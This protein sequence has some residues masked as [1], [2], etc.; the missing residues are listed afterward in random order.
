MGWDPVS[1][2]AGALWG[3]AVL[4]QLLLHHVDMT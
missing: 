1:R 3:Q 2:M 4:K